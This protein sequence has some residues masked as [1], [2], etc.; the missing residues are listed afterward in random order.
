MNEQE[1]IIKYK[2]T[3]WSLNCLYWILD[4][5]LKNE[6]GDELE[7]INHKFLRSIYNDFTQIQVVRKSSQIGF[8]VMEILKTFWAARFKGWNIIYTFPTFSDVGKMVPSKVNPLISQNPILGYWTKDKDSVLQK[9]VGDAFIHYR[10]T[11]GHTISRKDDESTEAGVGIMISSD[12]N[13][14]DECDRSDQRIME[15][16]ESRLSASNYAGRWYFSNPTTP[17]TLSQKL[18]ER[19]D[20]KHW[21]IKCEH[22]NEWQYL[23]YF[24][25]VKD[26]KFLCSKCGKE[27]L[28]DTRRNG[29]WVKKFKNKD[30][31]GYWINHMMCPWIKASQIQEEYETKTKQYFYNFVLGLP[32]IG[33]EV[34]VNKDIILKNIDNKAPNFMKRNILGADSGLKKHWVIGNEQGIFKMG[35]ADKWEEIEELIKIYDVEM[36][37][38]DALPDLTEPRKL[39]EKY[40]GIVWLNYY[41]REIRKADF[42]NWDEK[43]H[44]VYCDRSKLIQ[45]VIDEMVNRKIRFQML[46]EDLKIYINHWESLYK[47]SEK[48][49]LGNDV[50]VWDSTGED[51]FVHATNYFRLG[52]DRIKG[53]TEV[54]DWQKQEKTYSG[55]APEIRKIIKEE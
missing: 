4:S 34:C 14:H 17:A 55:L 47:T 9:K 51:H 6:K 3:E 38:F 31:S 19:S 54:L 23:D 11:K 45:Q 28:D 18:Y 24:K 52:L 40:P 5:K 46:P 7:F 32:Y 43:T 41:K 16:Y 35:V 22:C 21:F 44:T 12:L 20:Q 33:S 50:D 37:V 15:Q 8:T 42:I 1:S 10:G 48:D 27:I 49:S 29:Q 26:Y 30:I 53:G 2:N 36:A 13:V 25:N 39:R